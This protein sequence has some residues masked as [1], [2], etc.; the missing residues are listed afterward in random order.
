MQEHELEA[1]LEALAAEEQHQA[2][3]PHSNGVHPATADGLALGELQGDDETMSEASHA[4]EERVVV[5]DA[6][7]GCRT[8]VTARG[9]GPAS[10][11]PEQ[12]ARPRRLAPSPVPPSADRSAG[13]DAAGGAWQAPDARH[14]DAVAASPPA[15]LDAFAPCAPSLQVK[16]LVPNVAAGSII[17]KSGANITE[18]QTQSSARMQVRPFNRGDT[19]PALGTFQRAC[20][21]S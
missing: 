12:A 3:V 9:S 11:S 4:R 8:P 7:G 17:G 19:F 21:S 18:I 16:F 14:P 15:R 10:I 5:R 1:P 20:G 13:S 2:A 6:P